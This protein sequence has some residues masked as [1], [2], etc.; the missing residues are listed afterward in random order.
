MAFEIIQ[1]RWV[2]RSDVT[3]SSSFILTI[4][5]N[6][7]IWMQLVIEQV[8]SVC[9]LSVVTQHLQVTCFTGYKWRKTIRSAFIIELLG[10]FF[11]SPHTWSPPDVPSERLANHRSPQPSL[12]PAQLQAWKSLRRLVAPT[13][14]DILDPVQTCIQVESSSCIFPVVVNHFVIIALSRC[15]HAVFA[16]S[17]ITDPQINMHAQ[18]VIVTPL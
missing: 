3:V 15:A 1:H 17:D 8:N 9:K 5:K 7:Y 16:Q 14:S 6:N 13:S 12:W 2:S 4:E 11:P 18:T 10:F